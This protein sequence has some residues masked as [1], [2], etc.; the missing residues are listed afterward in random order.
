MHQFKFDATGL[1]SGIYLYQ[2]TTPLNTQTQKM[3]LAK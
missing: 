3:I 2:V 1:P